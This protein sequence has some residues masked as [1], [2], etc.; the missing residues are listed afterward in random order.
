[1]TLKK[2]PCCGGAAAIRSEKTGRL[3]TVRAICQSCG[4][5][6]KKMFDTREPAEGAASIYWAGMSWNCGIFE[7]NEQEGK[8]A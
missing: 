3:Y 2:C 4:K 7:D 6:G 1:M 5:R 8:R